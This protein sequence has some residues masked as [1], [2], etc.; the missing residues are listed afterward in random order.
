MRS[1][2]CSLAA[3]VLLAPMTGNM[4]QAEEFRIET[5]VF[6][7]EEPEI[8][9]TNLT[10]FRDAAVFDFLEN[11]KQ[12]AIFLRGDSGHD[13]KFVL[14][15]PAAEQR[16]DISTDEIIRYATRLQAWAAA[17]EDPLLK[18]ASNPAFEKEFDQREGTL[19]LISAHVTYRLLTVEAKSPTASRQY[20]DF[21]NWYA[22][23]GALIYPGST[24][25][26]PRLRVNMELSSHQVIPR[27]VTRI[28]PEREPHTVRSEHR[29]AWRLTKRDRELIDQA[30]KYL[31]EFEQVDLN[32]FFQR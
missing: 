8:A 15:R 18:F 9:G 6:V 26:F 4:I 13:G 16:C 30:E 31:V 3:L 14:L 20:R 29:V 2:Y 1:P 12:I 24:P 11:N 10:L 28:T 25:P 5:Q 17:Q 27:E 22:R 7:G 32:T 21:S 23:L 19:N